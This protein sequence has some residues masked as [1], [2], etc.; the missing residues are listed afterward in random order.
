M[1]RYQTRAKVYDQQRKKKK[2]TS[3]VQKNLDTVLLLVC[4]KDELAFVQSFSRR[5]H[6]EVIQDDCSWERGEQ[7]VEGK[8]TLAS[9]PLIHPLFISRQP[10]SWC[11]H[12]SWLGT[13]QGHR[14]TGAWGGGLELGE[15]SLQSWH[16]ASSSFFQEALAPSLLQTP[17]LEELR[18]AGETDKVR[19]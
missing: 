7:E 1:F 9:M 17:V 11:Q 6:K 14:K 12:L 13:W 16:P 3:K 8:L 19:R 10:S 5:R 2:K 15:L 4:F 18:L